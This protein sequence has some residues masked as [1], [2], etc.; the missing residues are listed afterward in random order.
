M[1]EAIEARAGPAGRVGLA[2]PGLLLLA[3][4]ATGGAVYVIAVSRIA[5]SP[6]AQSL[7]AALVCLTFVG[8]GAAALRLRPYGRFGLLLA[9]VG[10]ASLV[11]VLHESN[12]AAPYTAGV[13]A[14]N[15][16]YAVLLHAL[17]A[18]P[19]GRLGPI[20]RR[21]LVAAYLDVVVLQALAVIVDPLTRYQSA[22]PA[23][24]ALVDSQ[25]ALA[26]SVYELEAA[27]A[28]ALSLATVVVM[29]RGLRAAAPATRRQHLPV[30][31]GGS[32]ALLLFSLGLVLAPLSS[33]AG[34]VGF[35]LALVAALALPTA[36]L[37]TLIEGRLSRAAVGEL[38]LELRDP[39]Q[40]AGLE[41][42]LRRALGDPTLRLGRPAPDGGYVDGSGVALALPERDAIRVATPILHQ[43]EPVGVLVHD[44]S[45]RLRPELLDAVAAAAGFALANERAL[46]NAGLAEQRNRALLDAIPDTILRYGRDGTYL[47]VRPDALTAEIFPPEDF[48]GRNSF[49]VLPHELART[50]TRGIERALDTGSMQVIEYEVTV[51]GVAHWR[52]ARIVPSGVDEVVS[53]VRDFTEK[54]RA[55]AELRRLAEEQAALRRVATLVASDAAPEQVFQLVTEEVC[56]LLG[57]PSALLERFEGAATARIVGRYGG[58]VLPGFEVGTELRL[59]KG[60]A[61][62]QVLRTGAPARVD[63]YS[64]VPGRAAE[65]MRELGFRSTVA[66][67][68]TVAGATWG[69]LA[70]QIREGET[71]PPETE[72]RLQAFAELV[73]L[74]VA[75]AQARDE[76]AASRLRI[77]E[78]SDAERRRLERNLH[79]GAQQRLVGLSI[80][81][82]IAQGKVAHSPEEAEDLLAVAAEEL[83]EALTELRELAQGIHPAVL[84]ERG[85]A[86]AL[87]VLAARVPLPVELEVALPERLPEQLEVAAYYVVSEGLANVVKHA[88]ADSARVRVTREDG[89]VAVAVED[90][91]VGGAALDA[92]SGLCGLRDRV[93][94]LDG[95]LGIASGPG[96]GTLLRAELPLDATVGVAVGEQR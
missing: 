86:D 10:F 75:S 78:A 85:L 95:R 35:G 81:L 46:L 52:E 2:V 48:L 92:G 72:R 50:I 36:F 26:T 15:L 12:H 22:H 43:G 84:T 61:V 16:V 71:L 96:I 89:H 58:D 68:I 63:D 45:L 25:P 93:E 82:R 28:T 6:V 70:M 17:L 13:L 24:L 27:I 90:D 14:S 42:A 39:A 77:V 23:N 87:D 56:R 66:V 7:L 32:I 9:A 31:V 19:S 64:G 73:A 11:S 1:S 83:A 20:A 54:R 69:A 79:D 80:A 74:A 21:I 53:I 51:Q 65:L 38:L 29:T 62:A 30:V 44:R 34:L 37:A 4:A 76:L 8:A 49:D 18:Y 88:R 3:T 67:P 60:L 41:D 47:D 91:G 40:P 5:P 55:D 57:I 59:E 33:R 94:T